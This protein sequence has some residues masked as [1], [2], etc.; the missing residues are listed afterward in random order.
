[1]K[2][3]RNSRSIHGFTLLETMVAAAVA[4]T[5]TATAIPHVTSALDR[6]ALTQ[7]ANELHMAIELGR[8][9]A[10][11]S[12]QRVVLAPRR[13]ADWLSGWILYRDD[14][15]NG[16]REDAEPVLRSFDMSARQM[17]VRAWG[18]PS[19]AA[20]SFNEAGFIRRSGSNAL[21]MGGVSFNAAGRVRTICF[22]ATRTRLTNASACT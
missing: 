5:L 11:A 20:L 3:P 2:T 18:A 17:T 4:A 13:S 16:I 10:T 9:E 8:S 1:M 12:G 14:N 6:Q 21:A 19:N 7:A 15:D 22:S